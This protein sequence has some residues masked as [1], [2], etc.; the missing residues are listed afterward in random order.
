MAG[1]LNFPAE[2]SVAFPVVRSSRGIRGKADH[3]AVAADGHAVQVAP[4]GWQ[5][6]ERDYRGRP[7]R[8]VKAELVDPRPAGRGG[9]K[10]SCTTSS[11]VAWSPVSSTAS[12]TSESP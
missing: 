7:S 12:R 4:D 2:R 1:S 3:L 5:G 10:A 8:A 11:A 9:D 6:S